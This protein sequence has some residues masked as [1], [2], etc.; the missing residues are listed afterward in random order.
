MFLLCVYI[1][2]F[3]Q[4]H[5]DAFLC[6][7]VKLV[8]GWTAISIVVGV[9]PARHL[10]TQCSPRKRTLLCRTLKSG[11]L[12]KPRL[13]RG[14]SDSVQIKGSSGAPEYISNLPG[15]NHTSLSWLLG[16]PLIKSARA[17]CGFCPRSPSI[18]VA[19]CVG[20][21]S[22]CEGIEASLVPRSLQ[23]YLSAD[24][25]LVLLDKMVWADVIISA[26]VLC[27][28][29]AAVP[30]PRLTMPPSPQTN[31]HYR[32]HCLRFQ[33]PCAQS[34][35]KALKLKKIWREIAPWGK[36]NQTN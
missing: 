35:T 16:D 17:P 23:D 7:G 22:K 32:W 30:E 31:I 6:L 26:L 27:R 2:L 34:Q 21:K 18:C 10:A 24:H 29:V 3:L 28:H 1:D 25:L 11:H 4:T 8:C 36:S 12:S 9:I 20:L 33:W 5:L 15:L 13:P 14:S 19:L